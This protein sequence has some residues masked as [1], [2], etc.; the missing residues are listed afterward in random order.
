MKA[1]QNRGPGRPTTID[2]S[3]I[4]KLEIAFSFGVTVKQALE[5]AGIT[6]DAYYRLLERQ[7]EF[8]DRFQQLQDRPALMAKRNVIMAIEAGDVAVSRWYLERRCPEFQRRGLSWGSDKVAEDLDDHDVVR[9]LRGLLD[10]A[11]P[12]IA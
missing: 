9:Q 5:I 4:V 8:R 2:D 7:P 11:A 1:L 10:R 6:K 12:T 3:V